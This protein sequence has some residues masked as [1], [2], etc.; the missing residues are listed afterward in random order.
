MTNGFHDKRA[1]LTGDFVG[2]SRLSSEER[3][4]LHSRF[5]DCTSQL[6]E[7]FGKQI[8]HRPEIVRGDS[9][10]FA[11]GQPENALKI[12]LFFRA[13]I[14][15]SLPGE[16]ID[17]R[18]AFGFGQIDFIPGGEISSGDG[19]AYRLSGEGLDSLQKPFHMG[20]FFPPESHSLLANSLD[21]IVKL[22]DREVRK[23]TEVQAE[24]IAGALLGMTQQ[25]IA[26]D[27]VRR[28][29]TQ[30]SVAQHLERAGWSPIK[31]GLDFFKR[32]LPVLLSE[33]QEHV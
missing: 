14:R 28:N 23:W 32:S 33:G 4:L 15:I 27:W 7:A 30:Q 9:W 12:A 31:I 18:I 24:S 20:L 19:Q 21:V 11:I 10:Q 2:S 5:G 13:L 22:L 17:S 6:E 29:V 3:R 8:L 16:R 1:V 25:A 26:V